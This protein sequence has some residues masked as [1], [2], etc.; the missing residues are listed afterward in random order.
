MGWQGEHMNIT[1]HQTHAFSIDAFGG[2]RRDAKLLGVGPKWMRF[3]YH[4]KGGARY[5]TRRDWSAIIAVS[6]DALDLWLAERSVWKSP[7]EMGREL[8][9]LGNTY[10]PTLR[11]DDA[12]DVAMLVMLRKKLAKLAWRRDGLLHP[13]G[14]AAKF[15]PQPKRSA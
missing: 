1:K 6:S 2:I 4:T 12:Y 14:K 3:S 13:S 9:K 15:A 8:N 10:N 5:E 7:E 11:V